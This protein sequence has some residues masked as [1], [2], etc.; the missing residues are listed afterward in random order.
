MAD[1]AQMRLNVFLPQGH[2][3]DRRLGQGREIIIVAIGRTVKQIV[4]CR[5]WSILQRPLIVATKP[6]CNSARET[7]SLHAVAIEAAAE[8]TKLSELSM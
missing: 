5:V 2:I 4:S 3:R 8:A 7:G 1:R 6:W